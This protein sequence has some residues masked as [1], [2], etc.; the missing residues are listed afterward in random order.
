MHV[1][2]ACACGCVPLVAQEVVNAALGQLL[3]LQHDVLNL[4][5]RLAPHAVVHAVQRL[6]VFRVALLNLRPPQHL[7]APRIEQGSEVVIRHNAIH[8]EEAV[9]H[10]LN[11]HLVDLHFFSD[12]LLASA[13]AWPGSD[14]ENLRDR[15]RAQVTPR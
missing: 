7:A 13:L 2:H 11:H 9:F 6:R 14:S 3:E 5:C 15:L 10:S 12:R 8:L 4:S 1:V